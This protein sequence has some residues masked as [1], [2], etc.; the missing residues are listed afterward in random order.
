MELIDV[1]D[2][3][4]NY[5]GEVVE[6]KKAHELGLGHWE[7]II[8]VVNEKNEL[9][10]QKRSENKKYYPN[11]WS[12]C[13]GLVISGES[14]AEGAIRELK[15]ELGVAFS[16]DDLNVLAENLDLTRFY[17]VIC[18]K[19]EKDFVIQK[20]ELSAVKWFKF[21][22]VIN[23]ISSKD[24]SIIVNDKIYNVLLKLYDILNK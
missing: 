12:L 13:S 19:D 3:N 7:V 20:E 18:N 4:G 11:K 16:I 22:D 10:L 17:Y 5:T 6:R 1:V 15:E 14:V 23:M 8:V 9:L 2:E 21:T 24:D